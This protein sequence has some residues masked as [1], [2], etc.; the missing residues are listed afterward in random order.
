MGTLGA[1]AVIL[2]GVGMVGII[3]SYVWGLVAA[4][5]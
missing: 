4:K 2:G 1:F 5:R 3:A